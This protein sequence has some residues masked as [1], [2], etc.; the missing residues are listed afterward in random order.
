MDVREGP[1][2]QQI[3]S[4]SLDNG[5]RGFTLLEVTCAIAILGILAALALPLLPRSTSRVQ[6]E[7]YA[8]QVAS[9]LK[10]DRQSA[11]R[12]QLA[13]ETEVSAEKRSVRSGAARKTIHFPDDVTLETL[14][15]AR[16]NG[17][18]GGRG[19]TFFPSGMSCGGV[20][21]L[22]RETTVYEVRVNWLTGGVDVAALKPS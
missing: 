13:V 3:S 8:V 11:L 2:T 19:I 22:I 1:V 5:E 17:Q 21:R 10:A 4:A 20:I 9:I 12:R 7:S 16:C 14:L 18:F 15:S 6:L